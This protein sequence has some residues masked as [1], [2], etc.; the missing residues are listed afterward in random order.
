M[1]AVELVKSITEKLLKAGIEDGAAEARM[2]FRHI[3][4]KNT[5]DFHDTRID[6]DTAI[7]IETIADKRAEKYPLQYIFGEWGFYTLDLKVGEGVLIPRPETEIIVEKSIELIKNTK[8]AQVLDL[9]AGSGAIGLSIFDALPDTNVTCVELSKK[10]FAYL[11]MNAKNRVK[12]VSADVFG[13]EKTIK[14]NSIDLIVSN[15]PYVTKDEYK[16][17]EKE[18]Y[19]EPEMALVADDNG[20]CFYNYI[21]DNYK[22][23]LKCGGNICF[24]IGANQAKDVTD[25]LTSYGYIN[26]QVIKDYS[27]HDRCVW[28]QN[29]N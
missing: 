9:C 1:V 3:T 11:E 22:K 18:L 27:G 19:F 23:L 13:Y 10:A 21:S 28:A 20:L 7:K 29:N 24:E 17:L 15:P 2:I 4:G 25:I 14:E 16:S 12:T 26:C 6:E 8:T 5:V